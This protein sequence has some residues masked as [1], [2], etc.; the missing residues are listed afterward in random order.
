[1]PCK[2]CRFV[3]N[4]NSSTHTL[5]KCAESIESWVSPISEM[6]LSH[7]CDVS[8][9]LTFL[10]RYSDVELVKV[11]RHAGIEGKYATVRKEFLTLMLVMK[12]FRS[13]VLSNVGALS[14]DERS[15]INESY[16]VLR[17]ERAQLSYHARRYEVI[18][19]IVRSMETYY[20]L[21]YGQK[22]YGMS[23]SDLISGVGLDVEVVQERRIEV[24]IGVN[25]ALVEAVECGICYEEMPSVRFGCSHGVCMC[26]VKNLYIR[27]SYQ[28]ITCPLCRAGVSNL[29]VADEI[30]REE[31]RAVVGV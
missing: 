7:G 25:A 27:R 21:Q 29:Q 9:Q 16:E 23:M 3:K 8:Y 22:R 24:V 20:E 13:R 19:D 12:N 18:T 14:D 31:L 6:W 4:G 1:M 17:S 2:Y 10:S 5:S 26:C 15:L 11:C 28:L 30:A